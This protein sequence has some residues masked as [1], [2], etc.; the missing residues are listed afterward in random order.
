MCYLGCKQSGGD[1]GGYGSGYDSR[2]GSGYDSRRGSS[3]EMAVSTTRSSGQPVSSGGGYVA[4]Q[5]ISHEVSGVSG[6]MAF[7]RRIQIVR[8]M[9]MSHIIE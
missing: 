4:G 5:V 6:G 9:R 2:P 8:I 3:P 7:V 1:D